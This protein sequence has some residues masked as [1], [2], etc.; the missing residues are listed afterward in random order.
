MTFIS[1]IPIKLF[2]ACQIL[3]DFIFPPNEM[4][5]KIRNISIADFY[6]ETKPANTPP[7]D[8]IHSLYSYKHPIITE[9]VWQIKY[10]KNKKAVEIA[11]YYLYEYL[12]KTYKSG[13][14]LIPIPI[15]KK[16]RKERGYNQCEILIDQII[17][18]DKEKIF[19]K[20]YNILKRL[21][22]KDR[23]T[24]K[25]RN[26]RI[27]E[28]KGIFSIEIDNEIKDKIIVIIDDVVTTGSTAK[29][30][31]DLFI[32]SGYKNVNVLSLTR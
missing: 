28:S 25:K 13:A 16:R 23:Q 18:I 21:I 7:F 4:E 29:Q 30:A 17:K 32:E 1:K 12:L 8:F 11:S 27:Q 10:K 19:N 5:L 14:I 31:Y 15:S 22:H 9:L 26:E 20:N 3:L 2:K 24:L 6:K